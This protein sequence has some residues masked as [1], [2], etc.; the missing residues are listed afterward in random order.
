[1]HA[2]RVFP[3]SNVLTTIN[4]DLNELRAANKDRLGQGTG[5][6]E[7]DRQLVE[8]N[9]LAEVHWIMQQPSVMKAVRERG[10]GVHGFVYDSVRKLC[11]KLET[12]P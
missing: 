9:V 7:R 6:E 1:M 8:L 4:S 2:R 10:M 3:R 5:L 12:S 11:V